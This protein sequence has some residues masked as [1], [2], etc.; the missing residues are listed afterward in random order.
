MDL[1]EQIFP[2]IGIVIPLIFVMFSKKNKRLKILVLFVIL[3]VYFIYFFIG[4]L[5]N[6]NILNAFIFFKHGFRI[7]VIGFCLLVAT[8]VLVL[9]FIQKIYRQKEYI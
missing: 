8:S 3:A 9:Y 6:T 1:F 4:H 2:F 7:N 5:F